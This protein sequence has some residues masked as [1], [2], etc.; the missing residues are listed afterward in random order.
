MW[1]A[2][3]AVSPISRGNDAKLI[4]RKSS[5]G[6]VELTDIVAGAQRQHFKVHKTVLCSRSEFF[7]AACSERWS[8]GDSSP[9]ELLDQDELIFDMFLHCLLTNTVDIGSLDEALP[10]EQDLRQSAVVESR[11]IRTYI[12]ADRLRD[13]RTTNIIIDDIIDLYDKNET[14]PFPPITTLVADHT[15]AGSPLRRAFIDM[16]SREA[17]TRCIKALCESESTSKEFMGEV[18]IQRTEIV[19]DHADDEVRDAFDRRFVSKQK[20]CYY[21]QH[22]SLHPIC[23]QDCEHQESKAEEDEGKADDDDDGSAGDGTQQ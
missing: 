6:F 19:R 1:N 16:L 17:N 18:L 11:L 21:H 23:G 9:I 7:R 2:E 3:T 20:R 14:C 22:D 5:L 4:Q 8:K 10:G 15:S 13:S 12:L